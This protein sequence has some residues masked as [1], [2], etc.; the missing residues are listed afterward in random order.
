MKF[1]FWLVLVLVVAVLI[2]FAVSNRE[3]VTIDFW[4]LP[5]LVDIP[6]YL[7]ILGTL[8][9]G[10]IVGELMGW[11]GSWRWRREARRGRDRIAMLER[12]L[13][14]AQADRRDAPVPVAALPR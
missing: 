10:F 1:L 12:E 6:L 14:A 9:F 5:T 11:I 7:V 3:T 8:V 13:A 4:P 2:V